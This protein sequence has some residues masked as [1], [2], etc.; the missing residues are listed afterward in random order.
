MYEQSGGNLT[1]IS[2]FGEDALIHVE[3]AYESRNSLFRENQPTGGDI[4]F[5][6]C[7]WKFSI[8][9]ECY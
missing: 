2:S 8:H 7:S 3:H 6:N 5:R 9:K 4:F 1:R